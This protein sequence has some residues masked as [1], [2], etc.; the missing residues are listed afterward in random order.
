MTGPGGPESSPS[1][2]DRAAAGAVPL[3]RRRYKNAFAR[4][5]RGRRDLTAARS[6]GAC[7][8]ANPQLPAPVSAGGTALRDGFHSS[9][10]SRASSAGEWISAPRAHDADIERAV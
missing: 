8:P 3:G 1:G 5:E 9:T 6:R 10:H 7:E 4:R 2:R